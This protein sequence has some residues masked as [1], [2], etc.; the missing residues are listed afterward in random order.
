MTTKT[1]MR[2]LLSG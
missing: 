1:T 2:C